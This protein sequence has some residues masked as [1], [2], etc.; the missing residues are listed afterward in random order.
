MDQLTSHFSVK[1]EVNRIEE[2]PSWRPDSVFEV[3]EKCVKTNLTNKVLSQFEG[4]GRF[5]SASR[6]LNN[7][8]VART[9]ASV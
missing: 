7:T 3:K 6:N 1:S 5:S 4:G 8:G 9:S 2:E